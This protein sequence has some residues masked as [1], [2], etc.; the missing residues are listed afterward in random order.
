M[1]RH[2]NRTERYLPVGRSPDNQEKIED[3]EA[4]SG[5][6]DFLKE[7]KEDSSDVN[8]EDTPDEDE[9]G[10]LDENMDDGGYTLDGALG[11]LSVWLNRH[12]TLRKDLDA[13]MR[14]TTGSGKSTVINAILEGLKERA[15][16]IVPT[17][18]SRA[19]TSV[20]T[21]I[22]YNDEN[23]YRADI[24]FVTRE[25]WMRELG[26]LKGDIRDDILERKEKTKKMKNPPSVTRVSDRV[27]KSWQ[28]LVAVYNTPE[29]PFTFLNYME[30]VHN[31]D[32][33]DSLLDS[34]KW[35]FLAECI[36]TTKEIVC[37]KAK[38]LS[39]SLRPWIGDKGPWPLIKKVNIRVHSAV[40]SIGITLVDL[41][42]FGDNNKARSA[43]A[44]GYRKT[45]NHF[46]I[47]IPVT[48]AVDS[49]ITQDLFVT[50]CDDV[51]VAEIETNYDLDR[52]EKYIQLKEENEQWQERF[53]TATA[54]EENTFEVVKAKTSN[55][56]VSVR[57]HAVDSAKN[58]RPAKR[59]K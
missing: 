5:K 57:K 51:Q 7:S 39:S 43:V 21:E 1:K 36:G 8:S 6:E 37:T 20:I 12:E 55:R 49:K 3:S 53:N 42:G 18:S 35:P 52:N 16:E 10:S 17:S 2:R 26:I 24:H 9:E 4:E 45:V 48:R 54:D 50:K 41:P 38:D 56:A 28:T 22:S 27:K 25:E 30:L 15:D 34:R 31:S 33:I 13:S 46:F 58:P 32:S 14:N 40:L 59:S 44:E 29:K 47:V 23:D 19:C 11:H